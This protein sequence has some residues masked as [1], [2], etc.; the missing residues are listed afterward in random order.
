M[1]RDAVCTP[2][3]KLTNEKLVTLSA[4]SLSRALHARN[5]SCPGW[6]ARQ[7]LREGWDLQSSEYVALRQRAGGSHDSE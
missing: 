5:G 2:L 6:P 4:D 1:K 7:G 3:R